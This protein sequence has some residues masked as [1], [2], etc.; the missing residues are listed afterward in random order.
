MYIRILVRTKLQKYNLLFQWVTMRP[1][2]ADEKSNETCAACTDERAALSAVP[3]AQSKG[4]RSIKA[5]PKLLALLE[6]KGCIVTIDAMGCQR[7]I[8]KQIIDQG[9]NYSIGLKGNQGL[10]HLCWALS[11]HEA[12]VDFFNTSEK[13]EYAH[14]KYDFAEEIDKKGM[15]AWKLAVI[16]LQRIWLPCLI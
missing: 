10:L 16:G 6:L 12:V 7:N 2:T 14:V 15:A 9:G 11:K 5:I 1:G 4:S 3:W 13:H 8:T